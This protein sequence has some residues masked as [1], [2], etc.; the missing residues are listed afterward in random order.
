[1]LMLNCWK[2]KIYMRTFVINQK[3]RYLLLSPHKI[4]IFYS[5]KLKMKN[6]IDVSSWLW[7]HIDFIFVFVTQNS[8]LQQMEWDT[9][10]GEG[11]GGRSSFLKPAI[12]ILLPLCPPLSSP[13]ACFRS[14]GQRLD[15]GDKLASLTSSLPF[16]T[17]H[18]CLQRTRIP[19][20]F[21][22][23]LSHPRPFPLA[24][25]WPLV[26]LSTCPSAGSSLPHE[27]RQGRACWGL[28]ANRRQ[29]I[30]NSLQQHILP[31]PVY[32]DWNCHQYDWGWREGQMC[33]HTLMS[34]LCMHLCASVCRVCICV[35]VERWCCIW[36][37]LEYMSDLVQVW[38][39]TLKENSKKG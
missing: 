12:T 39:D 31:F 8:W 11:G 4:M 30:C 32:W 25:A 15:P 1:M 18:C 34:C 35:Q 36:L 17:F 22:R 38:K 37:L 23:L 5:S 33:I 21:S 14:W 27:C 26:D 19:G 6:D 28:D 20:S 24:P 16:Q 7:L 13:H 2:C 3:N 9:G 10:D 29:R